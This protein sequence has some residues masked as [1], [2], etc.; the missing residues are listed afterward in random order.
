MARLLR[1][2]SSSFP[3]LL[4]LLALFC[5]L[6]PTAPLAVPAKKRGGSGGR[7]SRSNSNGSGAGS[8]SSSGNDGAGVRVNR[9]LCEK[10]SRREADRL[11]DERRVIINGAVAKHGDTV[12]P[13]DFVKLDGK[14]VPFPHHRISV[15]AS[16]EDRSSDLGGSSSSSSGSSS[17]G[18]RGGG[19]G[20][21]RG[22]SV[23]AGTATYILYNKPAGVECTTDR[24][25][26]GNIV[27][28]V[29]H[30]QRIF[31]VGRLDKDTTGAILLTTNGDLPN[32]CLR[33]ERKKPKV[34]EVTA[35]R[36]VS[37]GDLRRL[38]DGVVITTMSQGSSKHSRPLTA[39]TKPCKVSFVG[40]GGAKRGGKKVR[41][42]LVEGRNRQ[43]RKMFKAVGYTVKKLH[44]ASFM[45]MSCRDIPVGSWRFVNAKE[46]KIISGALE[47]DAAA[48]TATSTTKTTGGEV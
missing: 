29:G 45:G 31:P 40:D 32:A 16:K 43:V 46:R 3:L 30:K 10:F 21:G 36:A 9:V 4:I 11:V 22:G 5:L 42:T 23:G 18:G 35:D 28:A 41:V 1:I 7:S 33:A 44:R 6:Q 24:R 20:G 47:N 13:E 27:D 8:G 39:R 2:H 34:Y 15:P 19:G 38:G 14:R 12:G 17:E 25:V 26:A 37:P 48:S